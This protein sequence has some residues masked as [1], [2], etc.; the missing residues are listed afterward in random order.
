MQLSCTARGK[1]DVRREGFVYFPPE[2]LNRMSPP[3]AIEYPDSGGG[4]SGPERVYGERDLPNTWSGVIGYEKMSTEPV[5]RR[6]SWAES[7]RNAELEDGSGS[8]LEDTSK[9]QDE[10]TC[11]SNQENGGNIEPK[12]DGGIGEQ[13]YWAE[14]QSLLEGR[15]AFCERKDE[16]VDHSDD[17]VVVP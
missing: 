5:M 6:I 4:L 17:L 14:S 11:N 10:T 13:D 2:V 8:Y 7:V 1:G 3:K 9:C 16:E 15:H 12:R